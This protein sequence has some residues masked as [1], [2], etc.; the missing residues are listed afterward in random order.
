VWIDSREIILEYILQYILKL[1]E[2]EEDTTTY[3]MSAPYE[4][5]TGYTA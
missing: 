4:V 5:A 3:G 1:R 2:I